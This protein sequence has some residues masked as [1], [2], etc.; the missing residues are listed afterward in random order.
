[1]RRPV[2]HEKLSNL[3]GFLLAMIDQGL[4]TPYDLFR[5]AGMSPGTTIPALQRLER[6]GLVSKS[7]AGLRRR[8]SYDL[9]TKGRT[10]LNEF[11][12]RSFS[13]P[14]PTDL[15]AALRMIALAATT[16]GKKAEALRLLQELVEQRDRA[17][18]NLA[19]SSL[20]PPFTAAALHR[21]LK[22]VL[23][24][25]HAQVEKEA[26]AKISRAIRKARPHE[27]RR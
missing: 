11:L 22:D 23:A 24:G 8:R 3:S 25:H 1:M 10:G 13:G 5:S 4:K 20:K 27:N 17:E 21:W 2:H 12:S 26:L 6:A 18:K 14:C 16:A 15:D 9:T 19:T 7:P